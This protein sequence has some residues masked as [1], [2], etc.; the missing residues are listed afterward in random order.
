MNQAIAKCN[1][2]GRSSKT[3]YLSY[4]NFLKHLEGVIP[5]VYTKIVQVFEKGVDEAVSGLSFDDR[6]EVSRFFLEYL[7]ENCQIVS[8]LRQTEATLKLKGL[9]TN[10]NQYR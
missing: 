3:L 7:Q 2:Q 10:N 1:T 9:M 4:V 8:Y 6:S 5:D